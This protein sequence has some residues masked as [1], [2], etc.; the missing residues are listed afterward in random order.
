MNK[1]EEE[2]KIIFYCA[3]NPMGITKD[4]I[5]YFIEFDEDTTNTFVLRSYT[6]KLIK[7][8]D[9]LDDALSLI[10]ED[11]EYYYIKLGLSDEFR[12]WENEEEKTKAI[13]KMVDILISKKYDPMLGYVKYKD[14]TYYIIDMKSNDQIRPK[15]MIFDVILIPQYV[16][17][18]IDSFW[19]KWQPTRNE[20][21]LKEAPS[22]YKKIKELCMEI[23]KKA[24]LLFDR[25][26]RKMLGIKY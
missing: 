9:I 26:V 1:D 22:E 17:D 11:P 6:V 7:E 14:E 10:K 5:A 19:G 25:M 15:D 3:G 16:L 2:L 13:N 24:D 21:L 20:I 23:E 12:F 8:K 18:F 4:N